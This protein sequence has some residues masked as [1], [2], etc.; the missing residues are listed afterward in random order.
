MS[1]VSVKRCCRHRLTAAAAIA[2]CA[3]AAHAQASPETGSLPTLVVT[4]SGFEQEL[5]QAPASITVITREDL[6]T[7]QFR[8]L[9]EALQD[10]EGVDVRGGTGKTGGLDIS[11]RGLPSEYTLVLI[12]GRRQNVAGDVTPN[13]FGAALNSFMPPVAAI[14]RIEIIRGP[15]STLYGSDA[16][17]GVVNIITRKVGRQ[18]VG[19]AGVTF[20]VPEAGDEGLQRK[21]DVYL[22]GPLVADTLGLQLRGNVYD[23]NASERIWSRGNARDPRPGESLQTGVGAK[24]TLTPGAGHDVWLD[25]DQARTRYDNADCR[26]G[27]V[28]Y[29]NCATGAATTTAVGYRDELRFNRDQV[30]LGHTSRLPVGLLESSLT[31]SVTETLGRT[32]PSASRPA[33]SPE[34]GQDRELETTNVVLDSKLVSPLG[35]RHV[36]ST[37]LQWWKAEFHDSL[38]PEDHEQTMWAVF[39]EDEWQLADGLTTTLGGRYNRHDAFGGEFSPRAY[40][41]WDAAPGWTLKGGISGGFKAPR[42]NQL[43]DGVSG[44]GGQGTVLAIGNPNLKPEVSRSAELAALYDGG[45]AWGGSVTLFR[46]KIKDRISS[47][48]GSCSVD[49]ISSCSAN[50][51]ATYAI[52]IDEGKTWG[53]ELAGRLALAERWALTANYTWTD[54]EAIVNGVESGKLSDTAEH[55]ANVQLRWN[56][57]DRWS[58]WLRGEYRGDSRRFDGKTSAL[59]GNDAL[60]YAALGDLKGYSLWHLGGSYQPTKTLTLSA[61]VHNLLDKD[62]DEFR[63]WTNTSGQEVLGSPYYKSTSSVR[64]TAPAGR[65]F[66]V[67]ANLTF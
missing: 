51:G 23:R 64:G 31:R 53:V 21:A 19:S 40:L 8:D 14:E 37:G 57:S 11:I 50:P 16:L 5:R 46:N 17:G 38:L 15:M 24:L 13:G 45:K 18:W 56:A 1:Q 36:L 26:L 32:I 41:V 12:D 28:D 30:A 65:T 66:W 61:S 55:V 58:A 22:S 60:E 25:L 2:A 59:A 49:W 43:I 47:G 10:V 39:A 42:L 33:G 52:N 63:A 62:F 44:I 48:G 34:I 54:S 3:A 7:R 4:A 35:E 20:G 29:L 9:A 67:G 6:Q 27:G